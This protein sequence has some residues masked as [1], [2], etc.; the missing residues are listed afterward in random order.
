MGALKPAAKIVDGEYY[1]IIN[2]Y[3]GTPKEAY[4]KYSDCVWKCEHE[5]YGK[6]KS[7]EGEVDFTPFRF[8]GGAERKE[9]IC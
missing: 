1:S 9:M 6:V 7:C 2:D 5:A 4:D 3:L 8:Q